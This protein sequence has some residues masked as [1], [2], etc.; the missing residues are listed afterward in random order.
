MEPTAELIEQ[1]YHS[2]VSLVQFK[3]T[4]AVLKKARRHT[5]RTVAQWRSEVKAMKRSAGHKHIALMLASDLDDLSFI[6]R[7]ESGRGLDRYVTSDTAMCTLSREEGQVVWRQMADA[8]AHLHSLSIIHDDVKP[9][10]IMWNPDTRHAVLIDFGAAI[11]TQPD[12]P[13]AFNPSGTPPY[14]PPEF[15]MRRKCAKGDVWALG[16][17]VLFVLGFVR[18][19]DGEWILPHVFTDNAVLQDMARWLHEVTSWGVRLTETEPLLAWM[20][21]GQPD[22]RVSAGDLH[23]GLA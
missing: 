14:A 7:R 16:I 10:N 22:S 20:L 15:L 4:P 23:V 21:H 11:I 3:G 17:T 5:E 18:L 6:L 13:V 1:T 2:D 9:D 12:Q 8:L 19:P